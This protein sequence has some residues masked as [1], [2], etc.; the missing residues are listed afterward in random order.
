MEGNIV[1]RWKLQ[2]PPG[3][4][5]RL[6]NNGNLLYCGKVR[7]QTPRFK[8]WNR[9]KGGSVAEVT[10]D[11][12]VLWEIQHKNHH[13]DACKLQNGNIM[14]LCL[15]ILPMENFAVLIVI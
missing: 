2:N 7:D 5:G 1:Q 12:E 14:L 11:S 10:W 3:L 15:T 13:H 9:W 8:E 6:L 4:Y